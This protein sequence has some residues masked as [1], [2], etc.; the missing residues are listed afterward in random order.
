MVHACM[1]ANN[2]SVC[3][4][5]TVLRTVLRACA[6]LCCAVHLAETL[7]STMQ[8]ANAATLA[9]LDARIAE[10][11]KNEGETEIRE[12]VLARAEY[13]ISIGEKEVAYAGEVTRRAAT[14]HQ[15]ALSDASSH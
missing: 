7:L 4:L 12:S 1:P 2:S 6:V 3:V 10:S 11:E 9:K 15:R 14:A 5:S 8:A 13:Q